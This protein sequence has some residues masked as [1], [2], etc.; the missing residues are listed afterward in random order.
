MTTPNGWFDRVMVERT[1]KYFS[2]PD[3]DEHDAGKMKA[4]VSDFVKFEAV[5]AKGLVTPEA[6]QLA[7]DFVLFGQDWIKKHDLEKVYTDLK[8]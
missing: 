4:L 7:K 6:R 1:I 3:L 8:K 5:V 2:N